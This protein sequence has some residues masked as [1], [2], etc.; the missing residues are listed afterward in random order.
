MKKQIVDCLNGTVDILDMTEK[1]EAEIL[2]AYEITKEKNL[3][4]KPKSLE[5]RI[6]DLEQ[7]IKGEK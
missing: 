6:A 3:I 5:D 2:S 4:E 1:E 7:Q